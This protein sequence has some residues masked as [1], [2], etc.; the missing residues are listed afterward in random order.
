MNYGLIDPVVRPTDW[1]SAG[2]TGII[3]EDRG[4]DW[5]KYLPT[6]ENQY[7][8]K[9]SNSLNSV[10]DT[11]GCTGFS[12][13]NSLEVQGNYL[14]R[15]GKLRQDTIDALKE[16][17]IIKD[18]QFNFSDRWINK[19]AGTTADGN[20]IITVADFARKV[21]LVTEEYWPFDD[22]VKT[23]EDFYKEPPKELYD[24]AKKFLELM[25]I[26]YEWVIAP[27][28][29]FNKEDFMKVV[30]YH[31]KHAP[32]QIGAYICPEWSRYTAT[33]D[34][35][36]D[37]C[38][39]NNSGHATILVHA[40][41]V[42]YDF[43]HYPPYLKKLSK[44]YPIKYVLKVL[45]TERPKKESAPI[46]YGERSE[47]VKRLQEQLINLGFLKYGLNTGYFG[48]LTLKAYSDFI[49]KHGIPDCMH[50]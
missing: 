1:D 43:D 28:N 14:L 4:V 31:L 18:N 26:K 20:S 49:K 40:D 3:Y 13:M 23:F 47:R 2:E 9:R 22:T 33:E 25:D 39:A 24:K 6:P 17:K 41:D 50:I 32:L 36:I 15:E 44:N 10:F 11:S 29:I 37:G 12:L 7:K 48:D 35:V 8:P 45:L 34:T 42:Y 38:P 46:M 21:G 19:I 5:R 27:G 30:K 16:L